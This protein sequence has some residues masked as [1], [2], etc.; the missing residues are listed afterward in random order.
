LDI[1]LQIIANNVTFEALKE[2]KLAKQCGHNIV[3]CNND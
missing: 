1:F 3:R 2:T